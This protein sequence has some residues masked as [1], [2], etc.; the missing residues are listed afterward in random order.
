MI[1]R[2]PLP[3]VRQGQLLALS[4]STASYH[5][6]LGSSADLALMRRIDELHLA[7]PCAGARM[8]RD[9]L[10][11]DGHT[12]GRTRV[13]TMMA[14][15]GSEALYRTPPPV[16]DIRRIECTRICSAI[17][18]SLAPTRCGRRISRTFRWRGALCLSAR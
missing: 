9:L 5:P 14:R 3:R 13:R 11:R 6:K 8:L 7:A 1:D 10:R 12:I 16:N 2:P 4:R 15:M 18:R 17:W